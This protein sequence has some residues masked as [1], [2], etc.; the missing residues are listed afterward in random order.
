MQHGIPE[1]CEQSGAGIEIVHE[2]V[3]ELPL[4]VL[5]QLH[6]SVMSDTFA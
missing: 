2:E 5:C 1:R 3:M 4:V 6:D